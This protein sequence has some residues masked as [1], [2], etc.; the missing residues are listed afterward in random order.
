MTATLT[1]QDLFKFILYLLGIGALTY[2]ISLMKNINSIA[3]DVKVL[4]K[5]NKEEIDTIIKELSIT[6]QNISEIT[7]QSKELIESVSPDAKELIT[8]VNSISEKIDDTS[9][10]IYQVVGQVNE[11]INYTANK[12][13]NINDYIDLFLELIDIIKSTI[14]KY[15][16]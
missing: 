5:M 10:K 16:S 13:R 2:L 1:I 8:N 7:E 6:S 14:K 12:I 4:I 9:E 15:K 3:S 11:S